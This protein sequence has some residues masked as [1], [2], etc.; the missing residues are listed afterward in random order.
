MNKK[1]FAFVIPIF[2]ALLASLFASKLPDALETV[3]INYGFANKA[4]ETSS[5]FSGY[6][7][8]F[9]ENHYASTFLAGLIGLALLYT[10][11]KIITSII[12]HLAK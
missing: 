2:A 3:A 4:K 12:K 7:F 1:I 11:F 10:L 5:L 9:V 8:P 6:S